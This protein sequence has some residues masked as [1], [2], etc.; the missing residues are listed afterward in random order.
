MP[1]NG[2]TL[3]L[4]EAFRFRSMRRHQEI[5]KSQAGEST[6]TRELGD[7]EELTIPPSAVPIVCVQCDSSVNAEEE[8]FQRDLY[9]VRS[10]KR[11]SKGLISLGDSFRSSGTSDYGH[12]FHSPRCSTASAIA[13]LGPH[14]RL[15]ESYTEAPIFST[16]R[17]ERHSTANALVSAELES[18]HFFSHCK[19]VSPAGSLQPPSTSSLSNITTPVKV[20]ILGGPTVGKTMLCRQFLTAEFM[21]GKTE[22]FSE[23]S[24][25]RFVV[26]E[27]DGWNRS[28]MLIDNIREE[29]AEE[30]H[31]AQ[32]SLAFF[33]LTPDTLD[34]PMLRQRATSTTASNAGL[35]NRTEGQQCKSNFNNFKAEVA[36]LDK[37]RQSESGPSSDCSYLLMRPQFK[38]EMRIL[39]VDIYVVVYAVD[40]ETSFKTAKSIIKKLQELKRSNGKLQLLYLVGN[41]TDLVRSRQVTTQR[42]RKFAAANGANFFEVSAA[43]NH[44]VDEL[45]VDMV[46][47][48]RKKITQHE[49]SRLG[50]PM[51]PT[52]TAISSAAGGAA[53]PFAFESRGRQSWTSTL[54]NPKNMLQRIV[55]QQ[56]TAKSCMEL[57]KS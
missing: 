8:D 19:S 10:F 55:K 25:E 43:I 52:A 50:F 29:A 31:S 30:V 44:L 37:K 45:L 46:V 1:G 34:E 39:D 9:R 21:G 22:S 3:G 38:L 7:A 16:Q 32:A 26:I 57:Q 48:W 11:T 18:K 5:R 2:K 17:Q 41:K 23:D 14:S 27:V 28:L 12:T 56:F 54:S 15:S 33:P 47:Q 51:H 53:A 35:S 24:V 20:Q 42:G 13:S 6:A 36:T 4:R 40:E 49:I